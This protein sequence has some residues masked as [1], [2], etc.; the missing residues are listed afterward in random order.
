MV[1]G[2]VG[3]G[4]LARLWAGCRASAA[5]ACGTPPAVRAQRRAKVW[6][7]KPTTQ[8]LGAGCLSFKSSRRCTSSAVAEDPKRNRMWG[9]AGLRWP[10]PG[11]A[12]ATPHLLRDA[13]RQGL[14][15]AAG[16]ARPWQLLARGTRQSC[17]APQSFQR[18]WACAT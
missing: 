6:G 4:G 18:D 16:A 9:T 5:A 11:Q 3:R 8:S 15:L 2:M 17:A 7:Q 12:D 14:R 1:Q 13:R 10:V